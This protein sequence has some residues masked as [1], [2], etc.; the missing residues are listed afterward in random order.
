LTPPPVAKPFLIVREEG[1]RDRECEY[2]TPSVRRVREGGRGIVWSGKLN[3]GPNAR[4]KRE[5]G[6]VWRGWL[7][8]YP[9]LR[10]RREGGRERM[11]W[12]NACP[13]VR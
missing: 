5:G 12:L 9:N 8:Q 11:G 3:E 13:N 1:R 4:R 6:R 10:W 7:K 2:P